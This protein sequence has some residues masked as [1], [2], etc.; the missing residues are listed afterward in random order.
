MSKDV[1]WGVIHGEGTIVCTCDNCGYD[2]GYEFD[3]GYPDYREA[4]EYLIDCGWVSARILGEWHDFCC[5][6]CRNQFIK[7]NT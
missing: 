5:E 3:C 1:E 4:Q 2:E 7:D 6:E